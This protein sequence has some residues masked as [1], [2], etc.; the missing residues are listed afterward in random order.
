V[1]SLAAKV[2][3]VLGWVVREATTNVLRHSHASA[4]TVQLDASDRLAR[5]VVT[6]DGV[7]S[8]APS[9]AGLSGLAERVEALGGRL[10]SGPAGARGFRLAAEVPL[11]AAVEPVGTP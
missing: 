4:V 6:D 2:D 3:A 5:L 1:P 7:G 9:G 8:G 10:E 11:G